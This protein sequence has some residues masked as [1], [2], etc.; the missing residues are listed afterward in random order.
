MSNN[1]QLERKVAKCA[2]CGTPITEHGWVFPS[3]FYE[4][5]EIRS[6]IAHK[7][8]Q[9]ATVAGHDEDQQ[10]AD[11]GQELAELDMEEQWQAKQK[12]IASI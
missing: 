1:S 12:R 3:K 5:E 2:G 6:L 7:N 9:N 4:G 11:F 10:I 8:K